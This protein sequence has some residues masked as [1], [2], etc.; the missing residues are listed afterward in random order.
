[1]FEILQRAIVNNAEDSD[2]VVVLQK[3]TQKEPVLVQSMLSVELKES[4]NQRLEN[5][6]SFVRQNIKSIFKLLDQVNLEG[7]L[8]AA[9]EM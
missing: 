6:D 1:M 5:S 8:F 9:S 2:L 4:L 3:I 7:E